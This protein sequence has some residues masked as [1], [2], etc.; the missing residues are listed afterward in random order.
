MEQH[1]SIKD[2]LVLVAIVVS[3]VV[4]FAFGLTGLLHWDGL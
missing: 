3:I 4:A 1:Y 2:G